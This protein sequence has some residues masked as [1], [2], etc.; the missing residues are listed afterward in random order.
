M[1]PIV[2]KLIRQAA[3]DLVVPFSTPITGEDGRVISE[4]PVSKGTRIF[5]NIVAYNRHP[6]L[7]GPD[8]HAFRPERWLEMDEAKI[9]FGV[10]GNL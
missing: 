4:V 10:H 7:W 3:K 9:K 6:D 5:V 8:P 1:H 2:P